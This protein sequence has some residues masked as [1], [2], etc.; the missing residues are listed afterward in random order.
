MNLGAGYREIFN[1]GD[2]RQMFLDLLRELY[3][4]F[5]VNVMSIALLGN[6]H[7]VLMETPLGYLS[8][9]MRHLI[10]VSTLNVQS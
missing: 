10:K 8:Q 2:H 1:C 6:H 9:A 7:H 5:Q 3:E 4:K